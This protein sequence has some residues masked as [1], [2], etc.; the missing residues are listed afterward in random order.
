M[1]TLVAN[2]SG[3]LRLGLLGGFTTCSALSPETLLM[4]ERRVHG[5]AAVYGLGSVVLS[6]L[7]LFAGLM[8]RRRLA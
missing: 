6:A 4:I 8:M 3:G 2:V 5:E 1:G 7:V